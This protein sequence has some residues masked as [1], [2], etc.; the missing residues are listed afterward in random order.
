M[1]AD[2]LA[3]PVGGGEATQVLCRAVATENR[4]FFHGGNSEPTISA[5]S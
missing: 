2:V 3:F 5:M 1:L 4:K